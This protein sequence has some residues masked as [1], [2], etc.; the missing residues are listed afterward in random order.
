MR[1]AKGEGTVGQLPATIGPSWPEPGGQSG[2][3]LTAARR[4]Y[5]LSSIELILQSGATRSGANLPVA[6]ETCSADSGDRYQS[7]KRA[8]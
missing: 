5:H 2:S 7:P 3:L 4:S 6:E 1:Q 8:G